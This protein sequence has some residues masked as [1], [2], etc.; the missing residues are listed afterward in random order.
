MSNR[1]CSLSS[2]KNP[3]PLCSELVQ[4]KNEHGLNEKKKKKNWERGKIQSGWRDQIVAA[5]GN[6][7]R[8]ARA[9]RRKKKKK[10]C[11]APS[12]SL[13]PRIERWRQWLG[14]RR[15]GGG[16]NNE[17][18]VRDARYPRLP[19]LSVSLSRAARSCSR[20]ASVAPYKGDGSNKLPTLE[21]D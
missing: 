11:L 6:H 4:K 3:Q 8:I 2:K 21:R 5:I 17:R 1:D 10:G 20:R 9:I 19:T 7:A 15:R 12:L 16:I 18:P 14:W 13:R